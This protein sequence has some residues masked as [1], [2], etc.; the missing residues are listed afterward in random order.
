MLSPTP[1]LGRFHVPEEDSHVP[2]I[3]DS[4]AI[5][6]KIRKLGFRILTDVDLSHQALWLVPHQIDLQQSV[7]Q[8]R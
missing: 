5:S 8:I 6:T 1:G 2:I 3:C 4:F 7:S